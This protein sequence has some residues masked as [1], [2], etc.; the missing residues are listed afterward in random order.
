[1]HMTLTNLVCKIVLSLPL[2]ISKLIHYV[3]R[4]RKYVLNPSRSNPGRR[5]K[6]KLNVYFH[7]S[8][9]WNAR[10]VTG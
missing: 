7:V 9:W 1:M 10:E 8:L 4:K 2:E 5:G 6:I 3:N